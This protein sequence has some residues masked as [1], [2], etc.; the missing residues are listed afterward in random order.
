MQIH[1]VGID[2][3][4]TTFHPAQY[5][6][7][8]PTIQL[9]THTELCRWGTQRCFRQFGDFTEPLPMAAMCQA[10]GLV[11]KLLGASR[12]GVGATSSISS[13][14]SVNL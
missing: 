8:K 12:M 9:A 4:K 7:M 14:G 11:S 3:G 5:V 2:L 1:S 13:T 6:A 10:L